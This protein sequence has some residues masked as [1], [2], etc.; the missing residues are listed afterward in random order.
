MRKTLTTIGTCT[1]LGV[2]SLI[3]MGASSC[4][5]SGGSVAGSSSTGSG[6]HNVAQGRPMN[7]GGDT[8]TVTGTQVVQPMDG[9]TVDAGKECLKVTVNLANASGNEW[10]LPLSD[11]TA[12]DSSGQSYTDD[13]TCGSDS[14]SINSLVSGGHA[15]GAVTYQVPASGAL[16]L[17]LNTDLGISGVYQTP[18]R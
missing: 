8:V 2:I 11:L 5:T 13:F 1:G 16:N 12:V 7:D 3:L 6:V 14:T 17:V 18:L 10:N 9:L 4:D 15:T